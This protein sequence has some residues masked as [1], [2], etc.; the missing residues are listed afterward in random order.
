MPSMNPQ[1]VDIELDSGYIHDSVNLDKHGNYV[2]L[3]AK[4]KLYCS[5]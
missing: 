5:S 4:L 2:A 3:T 1:R